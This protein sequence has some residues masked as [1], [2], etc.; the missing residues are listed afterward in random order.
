MLGMVSCAKRVRPL[1]CSLP[2]VT[3][4][5]ETSITCSRCL[6][7][8][9]DG[10]WWMDGWMI[11]VVDASQEVAPRDDD[12]ANTNTRPHGQRVRCDG[13]MESRLMCMCVS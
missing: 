13:E 2:P 10:G 5:A 3:C 1:A 11:G 9:V 8:R 4:S 12:S 6:L 7:P